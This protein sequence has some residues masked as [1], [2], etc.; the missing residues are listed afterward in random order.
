MPHSYSDA[1]LSPPSPPPS[2]VVRHA[3]ERGRLA[4]RE[5]L[6]VGVALRQAGGKEEQHTSQQ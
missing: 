3:P 2:R 5:G 6:P 1:P 4:R